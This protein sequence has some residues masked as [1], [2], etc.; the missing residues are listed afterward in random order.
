[1]EDKKPKEA[2]VHSAKKYE[3]VDALSHNQDDQDDQDDPDTESKEIKAA[4]KPQR[5]KTSMTVDEDSYDT[6][7]LD[8]YNLVESA[9]ND[10]LKSSQQNQISED[11]K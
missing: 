6:E 1:M 9:C 7:D 10:L 4:V 8:F 11:E 2:W 5:S 3:V